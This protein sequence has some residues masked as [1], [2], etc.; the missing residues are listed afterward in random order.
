LGAVLLDPTR[1]TNR[2]DSPDA[3]RERLT[4]DWTKTRTRDDVQALLDANPFRRLT[5]DTGK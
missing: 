4:L 1:V 3:L 5:L 2:R